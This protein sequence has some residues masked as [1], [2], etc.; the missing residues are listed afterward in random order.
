MTT[1]LP[2]RTDEN[3]ENNCNKNGVV[4]PKMDE[5]S[6]F[7]ITNAQ[8][9]TWLQGENLEAFWKALIMELLLEIM[10]QTK[11]QLSTAQ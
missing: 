1:A 5:K 4:Q 2:W 3:Q 6:G 10:G 9:V 11:K 7:K 8:K